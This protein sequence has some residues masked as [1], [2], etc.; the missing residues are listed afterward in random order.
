MIAF[1]GLHLGVLILAYFLRSHPVFLVLIFL[2]AAI[3]AL[4]SGPL[5]NVYQE[6]AADPEF[7]STVAELPKMNY[8]LNNFPKFEVIFTFITG[9][10]LVGLA[11][12]E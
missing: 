3:I 8:V 5:S 9:I 10:I 12:L 1:V 7:A 11:R 4:I 2:I 6:V